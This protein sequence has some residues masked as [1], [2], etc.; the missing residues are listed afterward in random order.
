MIKKLILLLLVVCG[1]VVSAQA[2]EIW[3]LRGTFNNWTG[4]TNVF[5]NGSVTLDLE[6]GKSY[7]F[8]V[9]KNDGTWYGAGGTGFNFDWTVSEITDNIS[10]D[11]AR[12][13]I[14][15]TPLTG[16]YT[17][18]L[19]TSNGNPAK[20][21]ITFPSGTWEKTTI[22]FCNTLD[23]DTPYFYI[24]KN[25]YYD[26]YNGSGSNQCPNGIQMTQIGETDIWKAEFPTVFLD[27]DIA[28]IDRKQDS[29]D[30]F[31][32]ANASVRGDFNT[33]MPLFVPNTTS[34]ETKN[35]T[36]YYNNGEWYA[37]PTYTRGS[38]TSGNLGT[39]CLPF[40]AT[41]TGATVYKIV[42]KTVDGSNNLTGIY[43]EPV[44]NLVAGHAYLFKATDT[45]LTAT[46]SGSYS[47]A[48]EADGM[49]GNLSSTPVSVPTGKDYYIIKDNLIRKVAAGT[50]TIGQYK[51]Y[52]TLKDIPTGAP[53]HSAPG[54]TLIDCDEEATGIEG[55][56]IETNQDAIYNLN[57]QRTNDL[58]KGLYIINGKKILV[59]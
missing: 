55:L 52:I 44:T 50:V 48:S 13:F 19:T 16:T 18:N 42:G 35:E 46:Y 4:N 49:L 8:K 45:S 22:Y 39:I 14:L 3:D 54:L 58:K 59:K 36:K 24:R 41:V 32:Q 33:S 7:E 53:T 11:N 23:W 25:A 6:A 17:F 2:D 1:G 27:N 10:S 43:A 51:A 34:N 40:N 37:Y 20:L 29:Y 9:V 30:N 57:G 12:N 56:E 28:F 31:Y 26:S 47:E 21:S 5:T 15:F 38:L